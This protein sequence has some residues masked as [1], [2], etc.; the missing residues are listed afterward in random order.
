MLYQLAAADFEDLGDGDV[1]RTGTGGIAGVHEN[2]I[3]FGNGAT[4]SPAC[5]PS[6]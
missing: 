5:S 3:T 4:P 6:T 2:K 1:R